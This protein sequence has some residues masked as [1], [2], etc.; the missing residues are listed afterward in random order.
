MESIRRHINKT[1]LDPILKN[2]DNRDAILNALFEDINAYP[3]QYFL[4]SEINTVGS[5]FEVLN[6]L[7]VDEQKKKDLIEHIRKIF[8]ITQDLSIPAEIKSLFI[9]NEPIAFFIGAGL[10]ALDDILTWSQLGNAAID[11][12]AKKNILMYHE[13]DRLKSSVSD[14]KQKISLLHN[15]LSFPSE[16]IKEFYEKQYLKKECKEGSVY[17]ILAQFRDVIK[18]T[19]NIDNLIC[20]AEEEYRNSKKATEGSLEKT[21]KNEPQEYSLKEKADI[22]FEGFNKE[23][24]SLEQNKIYFIHGYVKKINSIVMSTDQYAEAYYKLDKPE[25]RAFLEEVFKTYTVIFMGYGLTEL[26]IL[27]NIATNG[28]KQHYALM[29]T[30]FNESNLFKL[31]K[32]YLKSFNI[33]PIPYYRDFDDYHRIK[34][35]LEKWH[36]EIEEARTQEKIEGLQII[37]EV[38]DAES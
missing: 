37:K 24:A 35:V 34:T 25:R 9:N 31:E 8:L 22:I 14:P 33:N 3:Y 17:K 7:K 38:I 5:L 10:S 27:G 20:L 30:Y 15:K 1:E 18:L 21:E 4:K 36:K 6:K 12:L 19:S 16:N 11:Y 23:M 2:I 29:P 26:E 28:K 13:A 32:E